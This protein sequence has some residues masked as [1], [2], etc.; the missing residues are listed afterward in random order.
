MRANIMLLLN[1][2]FQL[3]QNNACQYDSVTVRDTNG[4]QL[5]KLCGENQG[6]IEVA[7]DQYWLI[8]SD[9]PRFWSAL[10]ILTFD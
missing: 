1:S 4:S 5:H 8:I 9:Y 6:N 3:E 2:V 10:I 7:F